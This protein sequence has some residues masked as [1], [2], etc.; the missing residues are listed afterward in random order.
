MGLNPSS[1]TQQLCALSS[2]I[3][4]V[5]VT[6]TLQG[7]CELTAVS[8]TFKKK[9]SCQ[10]LVSKPMKEIHGLNFSFKV[11]Q[12]FHFMIMPLSQIKMQSF[13]I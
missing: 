13:N 6:S 10:S 3:C 1:A 2:L 7:S 4:Q 8:G 12:T 11:H 9:L 5:L